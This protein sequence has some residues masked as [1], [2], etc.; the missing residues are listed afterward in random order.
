MG[1]EVDSEYQ[2]ATAGDEVAELT[3]EQTVA[4]DTA[5][6]LDL[7]ESEKLAE[8]IAARSRGGDTVIDRRLPPERDAE[9]EDMP[10]AE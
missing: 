6:L 4:A 3:A 10:P 8:G 2:T 5:M 1:D 7:G 9:T